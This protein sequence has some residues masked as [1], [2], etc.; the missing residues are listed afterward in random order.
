MNY[1]FIYFF[2][3]R[4]LKSKYRSSIFGIV[5]SNIFPL[6]AA[7]ILSL[8]FSNIYNQKFQDFFPNISLAI[9]PW[10]FFLRTVNELSTSIIFNSQIIKRKIQNLYNISA[11]YLISNL[12]DTIINFIIFFIIIFIF[13]KNEFYLDY[14][15]MFITII[16]FII[17]VYSI[18]ICCAILNVYF[19]DF[20]HLLNFML[21]AL[22]FL[23]PIIYQL[24]QVGKVFEE[25]IKLNP[26]TQFIIMFQKVIVDE[27]TVLINEINLIFIITITILIFSILFVNFNKNR[28][29]FYI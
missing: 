4:L 12:F 10:F 15:L 26:L 8:I 27:K 2:T 1:R 29:Q 14:F 21:Q 17:F 22:F 24:K 25:I 11:S 5:L 9:I 20:K 18:G 23:T 28:I 3:L 19:S 6:V 13:K 16:T 7:I